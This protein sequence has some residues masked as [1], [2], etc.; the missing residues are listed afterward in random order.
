MHK[1]IDFYEDSN[2]LDDHCIEQIF[3]SNGKFDMTGA[4]DAFEATGIVFNDLEKDYLEAKFGFGQDPK[5]FRSFVSSY[6]Q[7]SSDIIARNIQKSSS[8][9]DAQHDVQVIKSQEPMLLSDILCI[10]N[11]KRQMKETKRDPINYL[12][13]QINF[14]RVQGLFFPR[15]EESIHNNE[16]TTNIAVVDKASDFKPLSNCI[17]VGTKEKRQGRT[18]IL[19]FSPAV[20]ES[21]ND[22][23]FEMFLRVPDH[24]PNILLSVEVCSTECKREPQIGYLGKDNC[25]ARSYIPIMDILHAKNKHLVFPLDQGISLPSNGNENQDTWDNANPLIEIQLSARGKQRKTM[26]LFPSLSHPFICPMRWTP[27][28]TEYHRMVTNESHQATFSEIKGNSNLHH[29]LSLFASKIMSDPVSMQL[30]V[31]NWTRTKRKYRLF[32]N[33]KSPLKRIN[34]NVIVNRVSPKKKEGEEARSS[35]FTKMTQTIYFAS[36]L[37]Y[38]HGKRSLQKPKKRYQELKHILQN[39]TKNDDDLGKQYI[40]KSTQHDKEFLFEPMHLTEAIFC[41]N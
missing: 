30:F 4:N 20:A 19:T 33:I 3:H 9:R 15:Q 23:H 35:S 12:E 21:N 37:Y 28:L 38:R 36:Y 2:L 14:K 5:R 22:S 26:E 6:F 8:N 39:I 18:P 17:T 1:I 24:N 11:E 40:M 31:D 10:S 25:V 32:P 41:N 27:V 7:K 29:A 16:V 13:L 34:G